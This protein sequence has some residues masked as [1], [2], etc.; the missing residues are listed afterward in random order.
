MNKKRFF[1]AKNVA[2]LAVSVALV[3]VLQV[4]GSAIPIGPINMNLT[5]I[6][7]VLGGV[8]L[9]PAAGA[10]L[11]CAAGLI[12]LINGMT[13]ADVFTN[14]LLG[15]QPV[16]TAFLCIVKTT[17]AGFVSGLLFRALRKKNRYAAVFVSGL[18]APVVNTGLFVVGALIMSG[19]IG[20]F[21]AGTEFA[22][23]S[24]AYFVV[25]V[26]AGVNF[27]VEFALN[28]ICAPAL[29]RVSEIITRKGGTSEC[30]NEKHAEKTETSACKGERAEE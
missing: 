7:I 26:L 8:L 5:L 6:P 21:M 25:V 24:V 29:F 23:M 15:Q 13:G 27:L 1:S 18:A 22:G 14:F 12:V 17:A 30:E 10:F 2:F 19:T 28:A 3:V 20:E 16:F 9:G 11:G 4:W